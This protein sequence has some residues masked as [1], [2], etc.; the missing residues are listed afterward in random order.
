MLLDKYDSKVHSTILCDNAQ[1]QIFFR[2]KKILKHDSFKANLELNYDL[3]ISLWNYFQYK[4]NNNPWK[5]IIMCEKK[6]DLKMLRI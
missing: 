1:I 5:K 4:N 6:V 2:A 3:K